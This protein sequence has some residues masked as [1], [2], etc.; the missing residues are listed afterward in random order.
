MIVRDKV[1]ILLDFETWVP[2]SLDYNITR[3]YMSVLCLAQDD[4]TERLTFLVKG[5]FDIRG[6]CAGG[7]MR[8]AN[9]SQLVRSLPCS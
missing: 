2:G 8:K 1:N 5:R 4:L 9:K 7:D 6:R 3:A